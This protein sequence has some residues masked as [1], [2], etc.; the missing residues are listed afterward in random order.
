M[1]RAN[2]ALNEKQ[3]GNGKFAQ[4]QINDELPK[5]L[6]KRMQLLNTNW[7]IR[8]LEKSYEVSGVIP[9]LKF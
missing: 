6:S 2:V 8:I 5:I 4:A 9:I 3:S 1:T 7:L